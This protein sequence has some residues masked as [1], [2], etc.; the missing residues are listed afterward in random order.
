[1]KALRLLTLSLATTALLLGGCSATTK[2][3]SAGTAVQA[4]DAKKGCRRVPKHEYSNSK[5]G[6]YVSY[7]LV[8]P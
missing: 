6:G 7:K 8:C 2:T 5:R 3:E 1:M 4:A